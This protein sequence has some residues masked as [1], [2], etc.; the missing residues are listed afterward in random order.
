MVSL[1]ATAILRARVEALNYSSLEPLRKVES[2]DLQLLRS[3]RLLQQLLISTY[4]IMDARRALFGKRK[5]KDL[6]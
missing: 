3:T 1:K 6:L 4:C 5:L 2:L